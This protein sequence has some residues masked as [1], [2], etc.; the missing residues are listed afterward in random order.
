MAQWTHVNDTSELTLSLRITLLTNGVLGIVAVAPN[1]VLFIVLVSVKSYRHDSLLLMM[2]CIADTISC[3]GV[4]L[5][6]FTRYTLVANAAVHENVP[7]QTRWGCAR[8]AYVFV[9]VIGNVLSPLLQVGSAIDRYIS[10]RH[11][12]RYRQHFFARQ[13]TFV[14]FA[15]VS[16]VIIVIVGNAISYA[17]RNETVAFLCGRRHAYGLLFADF[18]YALLIFGYMSASA[19]GLYSYIL[20]TTQHI[21]TSKRHIQKLKIVLAIAFLSF[22]FL[23]EIVINFTLTSC[24]ASYSMNLF[25]HMAVS[26]EFRQN[27]SHVLL[28]RKE[29]L[30]AGIATAGALTQ[31]I[32]ENGR[33]SRK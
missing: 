29:K 23:N 7:Y 11:P 19:I 5:S 10:I 32:L 26:K 30:V 16:V 21:C 28:R 14:A 6:G 27:L 2:S 15:V 31:S 9:R 18:L 25:V 1:L 4:S 8:Y 20:V 12:L 33:H 17:R 13:Y 22:I 3:I 24:L